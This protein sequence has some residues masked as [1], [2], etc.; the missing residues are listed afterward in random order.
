MTSNNENGNSNEAALMVARENES[1]LLFANFDFGYFVKDADIWN[2]DCNLTDKTVEYTRNVYLEIED[3]ETSKK[4]LFR[5]IFEED[6]YE[7][8]GAY[9]NIGN[10]TID[11]EPKTHSP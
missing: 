4:C 9:V 6:G 7:P 10:Q 3:N 1:E 8:I 11:W 2:V 5:V